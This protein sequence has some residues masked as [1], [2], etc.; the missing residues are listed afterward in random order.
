MEPKS[1]SVTVLR[2][3][4]KFRQI[5]VASFSHSFEWCRLPQHPVVP[6]LSNTVIRYVIYIN[7]LA[8]LPVKEIPLWRSSYEISCIGEM[9]FWYWIRARFGCST[10]RIME[11]LRARGTWKLGTWKKIVNMLTRCLLMTQH[12]L[13]ATAFTGKSPKSGPW[14]IPD[15][16]LKG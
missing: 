3:I 16:H 8:I 10:W 2:Q 11:S 15:R 4:N 6:H 5:I 1:K 13:G 12:R 7:I 14:Y 9:A